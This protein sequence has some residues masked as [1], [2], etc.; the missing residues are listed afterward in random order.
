MR[1]QLGSYE[2]ALVITN[3][4]SPL[5]A[6]TVLQMYPYPSIE[7]LSKAF[8][9]IQK[10]NPLL[11]AH[12][13]REHHT[14]YFVVDDLLD[15]PIKVEVRNGDGHWLAIVERELNRPFSSDQSPLLRCI[16]LKPKEDK[17]NAEII[18]TLQH[19]IMDGVSGVQILH[20]IMHTCQMIELD[21][22]TIVLPTLPLYPSADQSFPASYKG[23]RKNIP[24][25]G[26]M[27][28]QIAEEAGYR[29]RTRNELRSPVHPGSPNKAISLVLD[30]SLTGSL[31]Q[32]CRKRRITMNSL[33][34]A[35][36]NLGL[37]RTWYKRDSTSLQTITFADLRPYLEPPVSEEHLGTYISMLRYTI[38]VSIKED[39]WELA[40][41]LQS[42]MDI[43]FKRG[44]KFLAPL[45]IEN[46]M[47]LMLRLKN[48]RMATTAVSYSGIT[49]ID[50]TFGPF[51]ILN[52]HGFVSNLDFGPIYTA[53]V[54]IFA[55]RLYWDIVYLEKEINKDAANNVAEDIKLILQSASAENEIGVASSSSI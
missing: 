19:T 14:N 39:V 8:R 3:A 6:V 51:K 41:E 49:D 48:F 34:N 43:S 27:I 2:N 12:I 45:M 40:R 46:L 28:R 52:V 38:P 1:R 22:G 25:L 23:F 35:A 7:V 5:N 36:L 9:I 24:L 33:L 37:N 30:A 16:Y 21:E 17:L 10:R 18:L 13:T 4:H 32:Q 44:E 50:Q 55:D 42:R 15:I 31:L 20:E 54:H 47:R 11:R 53:Q 29:W 26:Y